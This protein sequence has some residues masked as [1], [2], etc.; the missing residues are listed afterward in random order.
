MRPIT[1]T[2][3]LKLLIGDCQNT[4]KKV[5]KLLIKFVPV[6]G[7]VESARASIG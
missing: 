2:A 7:R 1:S 6:V 3:P 5:V 4:I